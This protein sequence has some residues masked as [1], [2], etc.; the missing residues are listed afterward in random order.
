MSATTRSIWVR[1]FNFNEVPAGARFLAK[2][3]DLTQPDSATVGLDPT[4]PNPGAL[5]DV[6]LRPII[7]F[8][9]I[10]VVRSDGTSNTTLCRCS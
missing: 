8:G 3:R 5:P 2:N 4:K 9:D 7:G 10:T 6:F 1:E